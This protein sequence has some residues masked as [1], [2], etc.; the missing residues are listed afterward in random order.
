MGR[1]GVTTL[2]GTCACAGAE[3]N[4][5]ATVGSMGFWAKNSSSIGDTFCGSLPPPPPPPPP[6]PPPPPPTDAR[7]RRVM[8][9]PCNCAP[10]LTSTPP[11]PPPPTSADT[12]ERGGRPP[13][14]RP[15]PANDLAL[16][17]QF[18]PLCFTQ[19]RSSTSLRK[20]HRVHEATEQKFLFRHDAGGVCVCVVMALNKQRFT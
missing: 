16:S 7:M 18:Y 14:R 1:N 5:V 17:M 11:G 15:T 12:L 10:P 4:G 3:R 6:T 19:W 9:I 8:S 2:G 13:R 20:K